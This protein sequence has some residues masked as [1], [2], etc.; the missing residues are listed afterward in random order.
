VFDWGDK[1][2]KDFG[3]SAETHAQQFTLFF[4]LIASTI[5]NFMDSKLSDLKTFLEATSLI[6]NNRFEDAGNYFCEQSQ[7][8]PVFAFYYAEVRDNE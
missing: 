6:W 4:A 2:E 5:H 8:D 3:S 7:T 1:N